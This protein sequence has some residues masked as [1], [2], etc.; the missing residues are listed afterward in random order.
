MFRFL[1]KYNKYILA[2]FGTLLLITFL[3]P[4]AITQIGQSN[5]NRGF[6]WAT[7]VG[8]DGEETLKSTVRTQ[9]QNELRYLSNDQL[10]VD[11]FGIMD[12]AVH[13][14]LLT[15]EAQ[16][17][18]GNIS[19]AAL[20]SL[21]TNNPDAQ[22]AANT[23]AK[24]AAVRTL[25]RLHQGGTPFSTS[26][27]DSVRL[28]DRRIK[29]LAMENFH[30]VLAQ[31][32]MI[33]AQVPE[34]P[35]TYSDSALQEQL[36]KYADKLP[37]EGEMGFGYRLPNRLKLEWLEISVDSVTEMIKASDALN[38]VAQRKH[39]RQNYIRFGSPNAEA[40]VPQE[41]F[42]D[43]L[44]TLTQAKLSEISRFGHNKLRRKQRSFLDKQDDGAFVLPEDWQGLSFVDLAQNIQNDFGVT[45]PAYHA[46]GSSW[47]WTEEIKD[48]KGIGQ[49]STSRFGQFPMTLRDLAASM[50]EFNPDSTI[51]IQSQIA[52]PPLSDFSGSVYFFRIT[53]V[54]PSRS[55]SSLN[56][57]RDAVMADLGR[58]QEYKR[59]V[60]SKDA[61]EKLARDEGLLTV[62]T[63]H[64]TV[65]DQL[66]TLSIGSNIILPEIGRNEDV[67]KAIIDRAKTI[68][69][70][71]AFD[72]LSDD[73]KTFVLT[74]DDK[75]VLLVVKLISQSPLTESTYSTYARFG[76]LQRSLLE[77]NSD[78]PTPIEQLTQ[79]FS[80][81]AL[82]ARHDFKYLVEPTLLED[83]ELLDAEK[84]SVADSEG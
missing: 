61:V 28:S 22:F 73:R 3:V 41:V 65:V 21:P 19:P 29:H 13:W 71:I 54:D 17:A 42:D 56:E 35:E 6:K 43:L 33:K 82:T 80:L 70:D 66:R 77:Q 58:I 38:P 47:L 79:A 31:L 32:V 12:D 78:I 2:V 50:R 18:I 76:V 62:A 4:Y 81:E 83:D 69:V 10:Q 84:V 53:A 14:Y 46:A 57:V 7:I 59:L 37:G 39:W 36:D 30:S 27:T 68:P 15:R 52:G 23:I 34:Q 9:A 74:V 20:G 5:I 26:G 48:I 64:N 24:L 63:E 40:E 45:L 60:Q 51:P 1:R 16:D 75:L 55:P 72:E 25:M 49:A 67:I 44:L 11:P 8:P